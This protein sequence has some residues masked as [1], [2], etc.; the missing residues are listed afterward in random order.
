MMTPNDL[1]VVCTE[2]AKELAEMWKRVEDRKKRIS[3]CFEQALSSPELSESRQHWLQE[4]RE[5]LKEIG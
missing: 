2:N 5:A 3:F 4:T 1:C